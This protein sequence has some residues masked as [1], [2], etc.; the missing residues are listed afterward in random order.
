M[1]IRERK[2]MPWIIAALAIVIVAACGGIFVGF[3]VLAGN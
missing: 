1:R 2:D 3:G